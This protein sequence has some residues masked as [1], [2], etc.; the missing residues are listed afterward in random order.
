MYENFTIF[1]KKNNN[2]N[3]L[4][5]LTLKTKQYDNRKRNGSDNAEQVVCL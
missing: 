1:A 3:V 5:F 4:S 2:M